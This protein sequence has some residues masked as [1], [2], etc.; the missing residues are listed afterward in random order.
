MEKWK[1]KAESEKGK[2]RGERGSEMIYR[3]RR[4]IKNQD[5]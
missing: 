1:R 2:A 4:N 5:R 3:L